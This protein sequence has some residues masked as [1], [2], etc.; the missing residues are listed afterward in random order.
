[1]F[2][3]LSGLVKGNVLLL[4]LVAALAVSGWLLLK[5]NQQIGSAEAETEQWKVANQHWSDFWQLK[6]AQ[7]ESAENRLIV[8]EQSYQ[9]IQ[10]QLDDYRKRLQALNDG[11][12]SAGS[13]CRL[14]ADKWLLINESAHQS[15]YRELSSDQPGTTSPNRDP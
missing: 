12:V 2:S 4:S 5:T 11:A 15:T 3:F 7:L 8:R 14:S 1:M 13:D 9:Q 10:G 6:Q